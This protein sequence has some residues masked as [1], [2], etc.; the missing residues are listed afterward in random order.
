MTKAFSGWGKCGIFAI[1]IP[2]GIFAI[3]IPNDHKTIDGVME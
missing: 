3:K 1:K 2:C